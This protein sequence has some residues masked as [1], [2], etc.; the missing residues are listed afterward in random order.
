LEQACKALGVAF[1]TLR[2]W[3]MKPWNVKAFRQEQLAKFYNRPI[4]DI[5]W[6]IETEDAPNGMDEIRTP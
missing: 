5:K 6:D 3:E 4:E 1:T 2:R